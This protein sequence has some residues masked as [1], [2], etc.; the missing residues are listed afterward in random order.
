M[1]VHGGPGAVPA[2]LLPLLISS[3]PPATGATQAWMRGWAQVPSLW[4]R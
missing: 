1:L 4:R 2:L 3:T